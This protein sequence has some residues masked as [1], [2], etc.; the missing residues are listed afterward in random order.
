MVLLTFVFCFDAAAAAAGVG[1]AAVVE[2]FSLP[3][4]PPVQASPP[5]SLSVDH[6]AS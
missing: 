3:R 2:A 5:V 6:L 4:V 1:G